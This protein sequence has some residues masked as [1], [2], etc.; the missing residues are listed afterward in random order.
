MRWLPL[1][2]L[3]LCVPALAGP[4]EDAARPI[5]LDP[6]AQTAAKFDEAYVAWHHATTVDQY[7]KL[8]KHDAAWDDAAC[9]FLERSSLE[10][11]SDD[12]EP[13][14]ETLKQA[15]AAVERT[16]CDDP[17]VLHYLGRLYVA[18]DGPERGVPLL[19]RAV[20]G[21]KTTPYPRCRA[22]TALLVL[23]GVEAM[24]AAADPLKKKGRGWLADALEWAAEGATEPLVTPGHQREYWRQLTMGLDYAG[25]GGPG[26]LYS[27]L[28]DRPG[29][30]PW[31]TDLAGGLYYTDLAWQVRGRGYANTVTDEGWRLFRE[32][33]G[34]AWECLDRAW[35]LH[36]D[37]PEA[38]TA[39]IPVAL[40][41][42]SK[43]EPP[44]VWFDR[45][46]TAQLDYDDAYQSY[47]WSLSPRWGGSHDAMYS[48]GLAC[49]ATHR[50]DTKVP[51]EF[52]RVVWEIAEGEGV[53]DFWAR[54]GVFDKVRELTA[55]YVA[56]GRKPDMYRSTEAAVAWR[57][58]RWAEA[59]QALDAVGDRLDERT[60]TEDM[61]VTV[62]QA[63]QEIMA[64]SGPHG[65]QVVAAAKARRE[66]DFAASVA[67]FEA[68]LKTATG[69]DT[70]ALARRFLV[71]TRLEQTLD[72]TNAVDLR[73][74][75]DLA[76]WW[77]RLG[78]WRINDRGEATC[79]PEDVVAL[80]TCDVQAPASYEVTA[81]IALPA[82]D[83]EC[84]A[85]IVFGYHR[86]GRPTWT[87]V[88]LAPYRNDIE[89]CHGSI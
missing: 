58:G 10:I 39:M 63:R 16:G 29:A 61:G 64:C 54:A 20:A 2:L 68:L 17:L 49:L 59:R 56:A 9:V 35:K 5:P 22:V 89:F 78:R 74:P 76:G 12:D 47:L 70:A 32:N 51:A 23:A 27:L 1:L 84:L 7:R 18:T 62:A 86:G 37:Y 15:A 75:T 80:L 6:K 3:W 71:V 67:G 21:Y 41:L 8:G 34:K 33:L 14:S 13:A 79:D 11:V 43:D 40:G 19:E 44:R 53:A 69:P 31:L 30:D 46:V 45:A 38:P 50:F 83:A 72:A 57:C 24:Q 65:P 85:G 36:P 87:N 77:P 48:F 26:E 81:R 82:E 42:D 73:P 28:A 66:G 55:G 88:N 25:T 52:Y 4:I 60:F